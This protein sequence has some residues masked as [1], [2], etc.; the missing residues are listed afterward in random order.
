[1]RALAEPGH[2]PAGGGVPSLAAGSAADRTH[3]ALLALCASGNQA[4]C[5]EAA[6]RSNSG[7]WHGGG[8][9]QG[10]LEGPF[11]A[12]RSASG[13]IVSVTSSEAVEARIIAEEARDAP[14]GLVELSELRAAAARRR[15]GPGPAP[16]PP[17]ARDYYGGAPV[18]A[19]PPPAAARQQ[20]G[21]QQPQL[22]HDSLAALLKPRA[23]NNTANTNGGAAGS[24]FDYFALLEGADD[25]AEAA[26]ARLRAHLTHAR[27]GPAEGASRADIR[28]RGRNGGPSA[29][30]A[31]THAPST[32]TRRLAGGSPE[33]PGARVP[34]VERMTALCVALCCCNVYVV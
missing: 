11:A 26:D 14:A 7:G 32:H 15:S 23:P 10:T 33:A 9:G 22:L 28:L 19:P 30:D 18:Q 25:E 27:S 13:G 1:M 8:R 5:A 12:A 17:P 24:P 6:Q 31:R 34:Y 20:G 29:G 16:A 4:A 21:P 3:A 2:G